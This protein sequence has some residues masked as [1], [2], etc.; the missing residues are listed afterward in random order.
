VERQLGRLA[1]LDQVDPHKLRKLVFAFGQPRVDSDFAYERALRT[2]Q[3]Y[4]RRGLES[5]PVIEYPTAVKSGDSDFVDADLQLFDGELDGEEVLFA[6]LG[7][8][9]D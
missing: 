5:E 4:Q 3:F 2:A 9:E 7:I 8:A 1:D 6:G